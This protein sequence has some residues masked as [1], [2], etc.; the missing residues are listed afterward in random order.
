MKVE[1]KIA[2]LGHN[3]TNELSVISTI[4]LISFSLCSIMLPLQK[5]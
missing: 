5:L 4:Q 2:E 3:F 1:V